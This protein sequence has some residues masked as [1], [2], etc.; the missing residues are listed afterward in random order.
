MAHPSRFDNIR[1]VAVGTTHPGNI[2]STARAMKTMGLS[3]LRLVNPK[4]FPSSEATALASGSADVLANAQV[5]STLE[6]A[7]ADADLVIATSARARHL[8]W[9][10]ISAREMSD[11]LAQ[12]P[13]NRRIAVLFG[14]EDRGLTND[15]LQHAN[16]HVT[17]PSNPVYGVLNQA[18]A[19][20]VICYELR[21]A[22]LGKQVEHHDGHTHRY[23]QPLPEVPWDQPAAS[24]KSQQHL[25][26]QLEQLMAKSG[27]LDASNPG[28]AVTRLHRFFRRARP[29]KM[30]VN[31]LC[32]VLT[33][34]QKTLDGK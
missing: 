25:L 28:Q 26:N 13:A 31:I 11:T 33:A 14:R 7:I 16:L 3:D 1:I 12:E 19:V 30:E 32:G 21:M 4:I 34:V 29:D 10:C 22:L 15:E 8:P 27:F 2:G 18:A 20:Q 6:E 5:C 17:I 23:Q 24:Q 9:P